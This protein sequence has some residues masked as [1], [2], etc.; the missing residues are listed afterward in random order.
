MILIGCS[1]YLGGL[2]ALR[3]QDKGVLVMAFSA[4]IVTGVF[5]FDLLP[6]TFSMYTG[7]FSYAGLTSFIASG[8]VAYMLL[9]RLAILHHPET[10]TIKGLGS[11]M[12]AAGLSLHG[13]FDGL[14]VGMAFSMSRSAGFVLSIAVI[15][16]AVSDGFNTVVVWEKGGVCSRSLLWLFVNSVAPLAGFAVSLLYQPAQDTH[17]ILMAI[18]SGFFL[19]LGASDLLPDSQRSE[20]SWSKAGMTVLGL[21][22]MFITSGAARLW[23]G[24]AE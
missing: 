4:G 17:A 15:I 8:F 11:G 12:A 13:L 10:L 24:G 23:F 19:Y 16:H 7:H 14:A 21:V 18:F 6:E 3:L 22:I 20:P 9:D 1:T 2:L 5:F